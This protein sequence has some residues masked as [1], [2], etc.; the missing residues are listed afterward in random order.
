MLFYTISL[1]FLSIIN[2]L[3]YFCVATKLKCPI[4]CKAE[5]SRWP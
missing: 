1:L 3:R 4:V 5:M 2:I